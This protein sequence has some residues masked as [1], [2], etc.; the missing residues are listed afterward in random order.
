MRRKPGSK[1]IALLYL[2]FSSPSPLLSFLLSLP[3]LLFP[4]LLL[5]SFPSPFL[6]PS[7]PHSAAME[8]LFDY[9]WDMAIIEYLICI[10]TPSLRPLVATPCSDP[11]IAIECHRSIF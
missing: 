8:S 4:P 7:P 1:T 10:F 5:S 3:S 11:L 9:F 2:F 6:P